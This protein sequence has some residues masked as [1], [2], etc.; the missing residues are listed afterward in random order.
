[1]SVSA[2]SSNR[3]FSAQ[4]SQNDY[5]IQRGDTLSGIAARHGVSLQSLL[6]ANPQIRNPDVIYP[7]QS[8]SIPGG[9][10][11]RSGGSDGAVQGAQGPSGVS[12]TT[13]NSL[14]GR[15]NE[16]MGFFESQGWTRAQAAGIVGNLQAESGVDSNRAQDGGGPGY[17]LAQW[18][19]PRQADFRAWAGKDIHQSTFREQLEFIQH[20]LTTTER[21]AGNALK[22]AT[23][24]SEAA[25]IVCN[26]YER[27]GI[28]H[29]ES[30]IAN[31]NAIFNNAT[32]SQ[33]G[34]N[35]PKPGG[36]TPSTPKP[37]TPGAGGG[38]Y[39]V[40]S[41]DT[42]SGIAGRNGVSLSALIAANP[43]IKNA[44]L[45]Y[46]GQ[47]VHIPGGSPSGGGNNGGSYTVRSGDTMSGIAGRNGVS[48]SALIAANPQIKNANLIYPGQTV[49]IPGGSPSAGGNNGGGSYTVRNGD[50]MSG[51]A[52]QHGVSLSAL[53]SANPQIKNPNLIYSGQAV[54]IPGGGSSS[55]SQGS[56]GVNGSTGPSDVKGV[57]SSQRLAD[58]ARSAAMGMGGYQSQGLCATGVSR[59]IQ[60][61]YG[62]KVWG[63]GNQIDDNLPRD[64]FKQINIPLS[65]ALKIP[66]L[67]L[68]WEHTSTALGAKYGHTAITLG[69]GHSSASDFIERN[70]LAGD[71]SR[72]GLKIF[73][74]I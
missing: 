3:A 64:K 72:T 40:R 29:M 71:A 63:N 74:P 24:A 18:E 36:D 9:G 54:H 33:P 34:G 57:N 49:H 43:Q 13:P 69:D 50:T 51:I 16:A 42:L 67:V 21:G 35:S 8:L 30:R 52:A 56:S 25:Q 20:E 4:A 38:N 23:T 31:A 1:M 46:P 65:E 61:T 15:I 6:S 55:G 28:P 70:T 60:N 14:Q 73:M 68:T 5:T 45:I 10:G 48:L 62:I 26:K 27:P 17:G 7:G 39:T 22:G 19:A 59:A 11:G 37:S 66:G 47:T 12:G 32:P 53:I 58:A 41:G 44:N 2:V